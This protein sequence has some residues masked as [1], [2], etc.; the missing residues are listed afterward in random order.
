M[1]SSADISGSRCGQGVPDPPNSLLLHK[2]KE[3]AMLSQITAL[4][5]GHEKLLVTPASH[6]GNVN[7]NTVLANFGAPRVTSHASYLFLQG[8]QEYNA[9]W[10]RDHQV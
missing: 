6:S 7:K 1:Y 10:F 2:D 9:G 4:I 3:S 8:K 5:Q